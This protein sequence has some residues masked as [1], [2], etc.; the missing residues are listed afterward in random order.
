LQYCGGKSL[1]GFLNDKISFFICL[2]AS[3][4]LLGKRIGIYEHS[5]AGPDL[6]YCI[7]EQ[8]GAEVTSLECSDE[9]VPIDT[10]AASEEDTAKAPA[11][12]KTYDLDAVFQPMVTATVHLLLMRMATGYVAIFWGC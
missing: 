1:F 6:Y 11:W 9:F 12:S 4:W 5:S 10:E 2:F 8:L 3:F 7:F